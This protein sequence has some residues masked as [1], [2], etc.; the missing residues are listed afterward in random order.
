[1]R[2][3][4]ASFFSRLPTCLPDLL[5][6]FPAAAGTTT[7]VPLTGAGRRNA[8][9]NRAFCIFLT[10]IYTNHNHIDG[11]HGPPYFTQ[12]PASKF[13]RFSWPKDVALF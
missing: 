1:M 6:L 3:L 9:G 10:Y 2:D 7:A 11:L 4:G 12:G 13:R 8:S 5:R